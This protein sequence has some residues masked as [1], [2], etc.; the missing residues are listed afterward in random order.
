MKQDIHPTYHDKAKIVCACGNII[1]TGSTVPEI[2]IEVCSTCHPFYT[3]KQKLLDTGGRI[4]RF[5][6]RVGQKA[7]VGATRIGKKLKLVARAKKDA[8]QEQ[9]V[10]QVVEQAQVQA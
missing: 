2:H 10:E 8:E 4:S 6:K 5:E 7:I 3:G 1:I 9:V